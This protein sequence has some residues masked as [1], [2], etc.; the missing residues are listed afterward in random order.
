MLAEEGSG[1]S[2]KVC[3]VLANYDKIEYAE[4]GHYGM[5]VTRGHYVWVPTQK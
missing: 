5:V 1:H 4:Q 3:Q 2:S